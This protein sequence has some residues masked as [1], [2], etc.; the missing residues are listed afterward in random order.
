MNDIYRMER[1]S[2]P[3][4]PAK[5][6]S[7]GAQA[8]QCKPTRLNIAIPR[9]LEKTKGNIHSKMRTTSNGNA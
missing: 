1:A 3:I 7:D 8:H 9:D 5:L 6:K 2:A 4:Q